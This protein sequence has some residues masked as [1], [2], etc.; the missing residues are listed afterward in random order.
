MNLRLTGQDHRYGLHSHTR[1]CHPDFR[2]PCVFPRP[3]VVGSLREAGGPRAT[4][5][6]GIRGSCEGVPL[7]TEDRGR[8]VSAPVGL[9]LDVRR[10]VAVAGPPSASVE[11]SG[12]VLPTLEAPDADV[13]VGVVLILAPAEGRTEVPAGSP[14]CN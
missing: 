6:R 3:L 7:G 11:V 9:G 14:T 13:F 8:K 12:R 10:P 4:G 2:V 5:S 1:P